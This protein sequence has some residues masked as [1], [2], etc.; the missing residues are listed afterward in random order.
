MLI[1]PAGIQFPHRAFGPLPAPRPITGKQRHLLLPAFGFL[2]SPSFFGGSVCLSHQ[3]GETG[4]GVLL[5]PY[6]VWNI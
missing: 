6:N 5:Y 3:N 1:S 2:F 4:L